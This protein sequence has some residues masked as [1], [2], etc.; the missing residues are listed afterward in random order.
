MLNDFIGGGQ[1]F[2]HKVRMFVQVFNR[3]FHISILIGVAVAI[4]FNYSSIKRLNWDG[5]ISYRKSTTALAFDEAMN[6]IRAQIGNKP[7]HVTYINAKY[8]NK[9]WKNIDPYKIERMG[10]FKQANE[11]A[12]VV[13]AS[14]D[15]CKFR[16]SRTDF[17]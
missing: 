8:G 14:N 13:T 3:S 1:V 16:Q 9:L 12:L 15:K 5:I 10:I 17:G 2:L 4:S 6:F 11:K 7:N